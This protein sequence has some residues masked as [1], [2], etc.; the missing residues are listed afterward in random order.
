MPNSSAVAKGLLRRWYSTTEAARILGVSVGTVQHMVEDG[1]LGGWKTSGG[2]RRIDGA[3]LASVLEQVV[4]S[5]PQLIIYAPQQ[6]PN[7][8]GLLVT[9]TANWQVS[10]FNQAMPLLV[11]LSKMTVQ[12]HHD[13]LVLDLRGR[14]CQQEESLILQLTTSAELRP[15]LCVVGCDAG[16]MPRLCE[17]WRC[18]RFSPMTNDLLLGYLSAL[19]TQHPLATD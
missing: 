2:H 9:C 13:V 1:R 12:H 14:T 3:S 17:Q 7:S 16:E 5:K 15:R 6:Q 19:H 8:H 18:V 10:H 4:T 11:H